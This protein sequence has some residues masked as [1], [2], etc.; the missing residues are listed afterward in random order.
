MK[1]FKL[2]KKSGIFTWILAISII[3]SYS[4][5]AAGISPYYYENELAPGDSVTIGKEVYTPEIAPKL[6]FVLLVDLSSSYNNDLPNIRNL[7]S[8][9]F[10]EISSWTIDLQVWLTSFIDQP[11]IP[12]WAPENY[13]F[14]GSLWDYP[15]NLNQSL[16]ASGWE[17]TT[18]IDNLS[19]WYGWD[20]PESQ[21]IWLM[22]TIEKIEWREGAKHVIALTTDA[23]FH[24]PTNVW[25]L[26]EIYW[27]PDQEAVVAAMIANNIT[28][29]GLSAPWASTEMDEIAGLVPWSA[30]LSTTS[31]SSDIAEKILEWLT[32]LPITVNTD[33]SDCTELDVT[34]TPVGSTTVTSWE[35]VYFDETIGVPDDSSLEWETLS[36]NVIFEDEN[37]NVIGIEEIVID[38]LDVTPPTI[39]CIPTTN[40]TWK[41]IPKSGEKS[42]WQN[43]DG[44]YQVIVTD[45]VD[46]YVEYDIN[47]LGL[48]IFES[49]D[50][51]KITE[52][53]WTKPRIKKIGTSSATGSSDEVTAHLMLNSDP[54]ITAT[55][56]AWNTATGTCLVPP[57]PK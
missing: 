11:I 8:D 37:K 44:F 39:M 34:L 18:A 36:C 26:W 49:E 42:K 15:F 7:D 45:N 32:N 27:W 28:F 50:K 22:E 17:W 25:S 56:A 6:D 16:T 30:V 38:V 10:N 2:W 5:I 3:L 40:P 4:V 29:I 53:P 23:T 55:D 52:A 21:Y 31:D 12:W 47:W 33:S 57:M 48:G 20:L 13:Y 46:K 41:N 54:I 43:E 19:I 9:L 14:T 35:T 1:K 51:F 24:I